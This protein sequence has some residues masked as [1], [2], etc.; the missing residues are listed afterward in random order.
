MRITERGYVMRITERG[1]VMR[2]GAKDGWKW[3]PKKDVRP[4][5]RRPIYLHHSRYFPSLPCAPLAI[6][7]DAC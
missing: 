2:T 5:W 1:Y 6:N 4:R 7:D 3:H